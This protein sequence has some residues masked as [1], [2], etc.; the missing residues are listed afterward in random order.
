[1]RGEPHTMDI[2]LTRIRCK[3]VEITTTQAP[4]ESFPGPELHPEARSGDGACGFELRLCRYWP[5]SQLFIVLLTRLKMLGKACPSSVRL[6]HW[7]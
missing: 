4:E 3:I 7:P 6:W 5:R 1:M 2:T